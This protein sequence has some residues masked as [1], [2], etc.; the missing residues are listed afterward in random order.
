[1]NLAVEKALSVKKIEK[2]FV[3]LSSFSILNGRE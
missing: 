3:H 1:M 2:Y